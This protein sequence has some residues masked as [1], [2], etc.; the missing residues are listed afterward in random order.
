[1]D[2]EDA[3]A[4][5]SRRAGLRPD[6]PPA[7]PPVPAAR[8]PAIELRKGDSSSVAQGGEGAPRRLAR[9]PPAR[10]RSHLRFA[11]RAGGQRESSSNDANN[12]LSPSHAPCLRLRHSV[13]SQSCLFS[14]TPAIDVGYFSRVKGIVA[15]LPFLSAPH[16]P[17][18]CRLEGMIR[19]G[20]SCL[21]ATANS[22]LQ[23]GQKERCNYCFDVRSRNVDA[24]QRRGESVF[25]KQ[26]DKL[27]KRL[28]LH[29]FA[30]LFPVCD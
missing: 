28:C 25:A 5:R 27:L 6:G 12:L 7:P 14:L 21:P 16:S 3:K 15:M 17:Y 10:R 8:E 30:G 2:I 22:R 9:F 26:P 13:A 29:Q 24:K 18:S 11:G 4:P 1:M 20:P 23:S 19:A